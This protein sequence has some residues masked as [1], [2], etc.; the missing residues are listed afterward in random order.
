MFKRVRYYIF[1]RDIFILSISAFGGP[2]AHFAMFV[3]LLVQKRGYLSEEDLIEL[4]ALCQILPGP[5]STQTITAVGFK[6]GGPNLAYLTLLIWMLPAVTAMTVAAIVI[7][8]LQ[9]REIS[10]EFTKYI[11]PMAVGFVGYAA[12]RI[13]Q[14]V[15]KTKTAAAIMVMAA[16]GSFLLRSPY[17]FPILLIISG[18]ITGLKYKAQPVEEKDRIRVQWS[19]FILWISVILAAALLGALTRNEPGLLPFR[20]FENF[21]RSGSLIFGGGQVLIPFLYTEFVEFKYY[22]SSE[23]FL[24]GYALMQSLPGPVFSFCAYIGSLSMRS[25]GTG[26][27]IIGAFAAAFGI[28]LPGTFLIFF[29]IRFWEQ[30]KKYRIIKASL[31]GINA[32]STGMVIAAALIMFMPLDNSIQ[33][34]L[35]VLVTFGILTFTKIPAPFIILSGLLAGFLW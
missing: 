12:L 35:I 32:A 2:Q 23:E 14:K 34:L 28:F 29:V 3:D 1:L 31:E 8:N 17:A 19:N 11:Q 21:Y 5:T 13:G 7:S 10:I 15:I 33:N 4:T 30:L 16:V 25:F 24:S 9:E 27:E 26:G 6:I 18:G 22:L 20:L